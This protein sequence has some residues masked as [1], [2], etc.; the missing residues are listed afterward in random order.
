[1]AMLGPICPHL[2]EE[3]WE[4]MPPALKDGKE[5]PLRRVWEPPQVLPSPDQGR[6]EIERK[7]QAFT[8]I[9]AAVKLAQEAARNAGKLGSGLACEVQI[10]LFS[11]SPLLPFVRQWKG[12]GELADLLV[13][14]AA[15]VHEG[16][17]QNSDDGVEWKFTQRIE[18]E[19]G[20]DGGIVAVVPPTKQK[21]VRCW[22]HTAEEA[23]TVCARCGDVVSEKGFA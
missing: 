11:T 1:M 22:K 12:T 2:V 20:A 19:N 15:E 23:D 9:T 13:V 7:V 10:Y 21:C 6:V 17:T 18:D 5:H 3:V 16:E 8:R 4:F 14:S